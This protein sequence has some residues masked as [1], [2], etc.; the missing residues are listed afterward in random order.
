ME[1]SPASVYLLVVGP[2]LPPQIRKALYTCIYSKHWRVT[3]G[4][5]GSSPLTSHPWSSSRP[6]ADVPVS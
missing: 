4:G 1:A 6:L 2:T 5:I 3:L